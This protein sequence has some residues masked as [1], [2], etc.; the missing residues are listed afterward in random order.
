MNRMVAGA[1]RLLKT[2]SDTHPQ[3]TVPGIAAYS[4]SEYPSADCWN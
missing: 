3:M 1:L 4:Y 2:L